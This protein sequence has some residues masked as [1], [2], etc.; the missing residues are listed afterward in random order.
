MVRLTGCGSKFLL[1]DGGCNPELPL[2]GGKTILDGGILYPG[3]NKPRGGRFI[4]GGGMPK[5]G[6]GMPI[7]GGGIPISDGDMSKLGGGMPR[8]VGC[9]PNPGGGMPRLS[10]CTPNPFDYSSFPIGGGIP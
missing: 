2:L 4:P 9:I 6:G 7:P 10:G 5:P 8:L 1:V 3:G